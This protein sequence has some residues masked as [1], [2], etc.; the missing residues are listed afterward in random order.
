MNTPPNALISCPVVRP[1]SKWAGGKSGLLAKYAPHFPPPGSYRRYFEPFIGSAAVFFYLRPPESALS[2]SNAEL[3]DVYRAIRDCPDDLIAALGQHHHD[4]DHFYAVR[5]WKPADLS[6]PERAA[7]FIFLNK[8]GFNGLYRVNSRGE[9]NVPFGKHRNPKICDERNIR[10][11]HIALQSAQLRVAPFEQ[12]VEEA[13]E[14]D[15][16]YFDPPYAPLSATSNFTSYTSDGFGADDQRKLAEVYHMLHARGCLLM[17]SN[18]SAPLIYDLFEGYGYHLHEVTARRAIN[19]KANG[20]GE[21]KELLI[22]NFV[23][24]EG[25]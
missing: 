19:S 21:I 23:W 3:I 18:S 4:R 15:L 25:Q 7:R 20:R 22:T 11:A 13:T 12:A 14:G 2:D 8:T 1:V 24:G 17:L 5:A 9:F 6:L 16:I 10:A